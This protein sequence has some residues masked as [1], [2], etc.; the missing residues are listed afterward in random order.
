MKEIIGITHSSWGELTSASSVESLACP[1]VSYFLKH[2]QAGDSTELA[3]VSLPHDAIGIATSE[4]I[5]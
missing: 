3:E 2:G 1:S 4:P 5:L